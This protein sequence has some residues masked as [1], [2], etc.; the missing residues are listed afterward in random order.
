ME[1]KKKISPQAIL[2]LKEALSVI[3]WK[4]ED[5]QQFIKL[6]I[7]NPAIISTINW[8]VTK[9]EIVKELL[10][11]MT[12]RLD[13]YESDLLN[14]VMAVTDFNDF[15]NLKYWDEDGSKTKKPKKPYII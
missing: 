9:R 15:G 3:Y 13:I 10:N 1:T 12:N 5:L 4:K 6:T 14:L 11:R 2:A 7:D 8:A